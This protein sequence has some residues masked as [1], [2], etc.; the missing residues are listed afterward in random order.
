[1]INNRNEIYKSIVQYDFFQ[2]T[3]ENTFIEKVDEL[4]KAINNSINNI[5]KEIMQK[6]KEVHMALSGGVDSSTILMTLIQHNFPVVTHT[7]AINGDHPDMYYAKKLSK[8]LGVKHHSYV[9]KPTQKNMNV[10]KY[11]LLYN[12]VKENTKNIICGDCIDEELGGYYP[13][14]NPTPQ[15]FPLYDATKTK[16]ENQIGALEYFMHRLI[17]DHLFEQNSCSDSCSIEVFLPYADKNVFKAAS[18]FN[19]NE[20]LDDVDRKK[21]MLEIGLRKGL[22][23]EILQRRKYGLISAMDDIHVK[24]M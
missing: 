15:K 6:Q 2:D 4:E 11:F 3:N 21:P 17:F 9:I 5:G 14:Q 13:H 22:P 23:L 24:L 10:S 19:L 8:K 20:L 7:I 1:M 16:K 12:A 18:R